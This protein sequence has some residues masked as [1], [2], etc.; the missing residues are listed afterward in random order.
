MNDNYTSNA[1]ILNHIFLDNYF[2]GYK[3]LKIRNKSTLLPLISSSYRKWF[4]SSLIEKTTLTPSAIF[5]KM[6]D[7]NLILPSLRFETSTSKSNF[8]FVDVTYTLDNHPIINDLRI[9]LDFCMPYLEL[10]E[11]DFLTT[12]DSSSLAK[13]ISLQD[14]FYAEYLFDLAVQLKLLE[15]MPSIYSNKAQVSNYSEKFY[16]KPKR[17]I[18]NKIFDACLEIL[19]LQMK[20]ILPLHTT[21]FQKQFF[22]DFIKYPKPIDYFFH[23][24]YSSLGLNF[25]SLMSEFESGTVN[26]SHLY[27][28]FGDALLSSTYLLGIVLDKYLLTPIGYYLK[29][30]TPMYSIPY[31]FQEELTFLHETM[32]TQV[33][34]NPSLWSP[35]SNFFLTKLGLEFLELDPDEENYTELPNSIPL[36]HLL[37]IQESVRLQQIVNNTKISIS[38]IGN[39]YEFKANITLHRNFWFNFEIYQD[40]TLAVIHEQ[41]CDMLLLDSFAEYSI[42]VGE[43]ESPFLTYVSA[44]SRK[45]FKKADS[46]LIKDLNLEK[47]NILTY[48]IVNAGNSP[49]GSVGAMKIQL[50]VVAVKEASP[51]IFY[52]IV[53]KKSKAFAEWENSIDTNSFF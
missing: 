2:A 25:E 15:K 7:D 32:K 29:L 1:D 48:S 16:K 46:T 38:S 20:S 47:G 8:Y 42:S 30:I 11:E 24:V 6:S 35:C 40:S 27:D 53:S 14:I 21:P 51:R 41:F 9:L 19:S 12:E 37:I 4:F 50:S 43:I 26:V 31:D 3:N 44:G 52:P 22:L 45:K 49:L 17:E 39:S 18:L 10:T 33:D 5:N 13:L 28:D 23:E 36:D 34:L